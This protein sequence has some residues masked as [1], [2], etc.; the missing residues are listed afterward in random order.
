MITETGKWIDTRQGKKGPRT[1]ISTR[2]LILQDMG[3]G[4]EEYY[5][6]Q[7]L[8]H[9]AGSFEELV[10][11]IRAKADGNVGNDPDQMARELQKVLVEKGPAFRHTPEFFRAIEQERIRQ[12]AYRGVVVTGIV[13]EE[14]RDIRD[15]PFQYLGLPPNATFSQVRTAYI[16]LSKLLHPD[17]QRPEDPNMRTAI[18][19]TR[20]RLV[21]GQSIEDFLQELEKTSRPDMLTACELTRMNE[22]QR[23]E[24][25]QKH[26]AYQALE[27]KYERVREEMRSRALERM[28]K[29]TRA[30]RIAKAMLSHQ[31]AEL[32]GYEWE[33]AETVPFPGTG[34]GDHITLE[35]D[36]L[37]LEGDGEIRRD[38][39]RFADEHESVYIA[40]D[41]GVPYCSE[42]DFM[43]R[44]YLKDLFAW[45][46][47]V[48]GRQLSP[49]LLTDM[50]RR[51]R[52]SDDQTEQ[53]RLM[54]MNGESPGFVAETLGMSTS[55]HEHYPLMRFV[56]D[57]IC[58]PTFYHQ[59]APR[60]SHEFSLGVELAPNG[61]LVF[62]HRSQEDQMNFWTA[63]VPKVVQFTPQDVLMMVNIAYGPLL[64]NTGH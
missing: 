21:S 9:L 20:G 49:L 31:S 56:D 11:K 37:R 13:A 38:K 19:G 41:L 5:E 12:E 10:P 33:H 1:D 58:G 15:N 62:R 27:R 45:M 42:P 24:Y 63:G 40:Y 25:V 52:F 29:I 34:W 18:F 55:G 51:Y 3:S 4:D 47:V 22:A 28:Q 32:E 46:D 30:Y 35:Y 26:G 43:M 54:L 57:V 17:V 50:V 44:A 60:D 23:A 64:G 16:T 53:L 7:R 61:G 8:E 2:N 59:T 39:G 36:R 14:E 48:Q 6:G